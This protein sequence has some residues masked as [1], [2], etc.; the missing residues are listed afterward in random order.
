MYCGENGIISLILSDPLSQLMSMLPLSNHSQLTTNAVGFYFNDEVYLYRTYDSNRVNWL[1]TSL[2][3]LYLSSFIESITLYTNII[4]PDYKFVKRA[5]KIIATTTITTFIYDDILLSI[6]DVGNEHKIITGYTL[7]NKCFTKNDNVSNH[8]FLDNIIEKHKTIIP[9]TITPTESTYHHI[10]NLIRKDIVNLLGS[11]ASLY[12]FNYQF[13][14][15]LLNPQSNLKLTTKNIPLKNLKKDNLSSLGNKLKELTHTCKK[16]T[17]Y[18]LDI[19]ELIYYYNKL[20]IDLKSPLEPLK[21]S[22]NI[23][24]KNITITSNNSLRND[25]HMINNN[26][27]ILIPMYN[28]NLSDLSKEELLEILVYIDELNNPHGNNKKYFISLQN[29]IVKEISKRNK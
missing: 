17:P 23:L 8:K 27:N 26:L 28:P 1:P 25:L 4:I 10:I 29:T 19:G 18:V 22:K 11:F 15:N 9:S 16:N 7:I 13:R 12:L 21:M 5:R 20:L 6:F 24:S 3:E 14:L 2:K